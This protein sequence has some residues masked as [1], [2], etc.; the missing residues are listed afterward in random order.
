[1]DATRCPDGKDSGATCLSDAQIQVVNTFRSPLKLGYSIPGQL[2]EYPGDPVGAEASLNWVAS[3]AQPDPARLFYPF[4]S[5]YQVLMKDPSLTVATFDSVR[6]AP[7][8]Q[9][10]SEELDA[11]ADWSKFFAKHGKVIYATAA[12]DYTTNANAHIMMYQAVVKQAGQAVADRSLRFYVTPGG[13]HGS[14]SYSFP[15]KLAQPRQMDLITVLTDWVER[16]K[17]PPDAIEQLSVEAAAPYTITQ[18]R[19]LCRYPKYPRFMG[20]GDPKVASAYV[21]AAP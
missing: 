18:S 16:G 4:V 9:K 2:N 13:D 8:L 3:R 7:Q 17:T 19:P 10:I 20:K 15:D 5:F 1:M 12:D 11:P 21:C 14:R 6:L